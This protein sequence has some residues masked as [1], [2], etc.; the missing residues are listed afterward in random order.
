[1]SSLFHLASCPLGLSM[2]PHGKQYGGYSEIKSRTTIWYSNLTSGYMSKRIEIRISNRYLHPSVHYSII[3][4]T[5]IRKQPK[6]PTTDEWV[7]KM[8]CMCTM[9]HYSALKKISHWTS[10]GII[11]CLLYKNIMAYGLIKKQI[12]KM[13]ELWFIRNINQFYYFSEMKNITRL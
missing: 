8:K 10:K 12:L 4:Y 13:I 2:L 5:K 3:H 1:M 7:G 9:E 6:F 11:G